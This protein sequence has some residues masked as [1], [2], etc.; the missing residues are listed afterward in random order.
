MFARAGDTW[1]GVHNLVPTCSHV[2]CR[3]QR[4]IMKFNA[5]L[6]LESVGQAVIRGLRHL[7]AEI[8]PKV[9]GRRGI[10]RIDADQNAV[11]WRRRLKHGERR[12]SMTVQTRAA[13]SSDHIG[14]SPPMFWCCVR[15]C[16]S[17]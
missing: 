14:Q 5:S 11:E 12:L 3:E 8:T 13:I 6:D 10:V 9:G 4:A 1:A 15:G 7:R 2:L 17:S 16:G